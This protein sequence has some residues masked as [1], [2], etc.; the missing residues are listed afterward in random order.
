[1]SCMQ[2]SKQCQSGG[3]VQLYHKLTSYKPQIGVLPQA[4]SHHRSLHSCQRRDL[5]GMPKP[6]S[7]IHTMLVSAQCTR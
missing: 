4:H 2:L 1:M 6:A 7:A 3:L 5:A